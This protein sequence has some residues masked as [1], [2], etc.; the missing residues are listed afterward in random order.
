MGLEKIVVTH[1]EWWIVG[2]TLEDQIRITKD[3]N[4]YLERCFAQP[5]GGGKI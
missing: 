5:M 2:M 3:Y 1:P 4:V